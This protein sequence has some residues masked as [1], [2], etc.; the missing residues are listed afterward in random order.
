MYTER[1]AIN[2]ELYFNRSTIQELRDE[3]IELLK[4]LRELDERD[5]GD[6][7]SYDGLKFLTEQLNEAIAAISE[8]VPKVSVSEVLEHVSK[9]VNKNQIIPTKEKEEMPEIKALREK[10]LEKKRKVEY[11]S[12]ERASSVILQILEEKKEAKTKE[13]ELEFYKRT[14]KKYANFYEKLTNAIQQYPDKI[15]KRR[16]GLYNYIGE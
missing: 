14:G 10:D 16:G 3:N 12:S 13:I 6:S 4:R 1:Q 5:M 11:M 2:D 8:L 9:D 7:V 15:S